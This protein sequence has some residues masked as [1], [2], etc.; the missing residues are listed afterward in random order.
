MVILIKKRFFINAERFMLFLFFAL[1]FTFL[2]Y[3]TGNFQYFLDSN[4]IMLI[5]ITNITSLIL[6]VCTVYYGTIIRVT[7][8]G[9]RIT[10]RKRIRKYIFFAVLFLFSIIILIISRFILV[11]AKG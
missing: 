10:K 3:L 7:N 11:W 8:L 6:L 2:L 9:K 1:S 4:Q 5:R